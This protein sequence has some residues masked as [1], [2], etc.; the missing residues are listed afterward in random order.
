MHMALIGPRFVFQERT[1]LSPTDEVRPSRML[2]F[3]GS[4]RYDIDI[5]VEVC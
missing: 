3:G 2:D 4:V 5:V 1:V